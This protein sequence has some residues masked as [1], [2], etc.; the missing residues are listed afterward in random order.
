MS[1]LLSL[2]GGKLL[3]A[4]AAGLA[5]LLALWRAHAAGRQAEQNK[6][7]RKTLDAVKQQR[8]S[9]EKIDRVGDGDLDNWMR[10]HGDFRD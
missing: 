9:D 4:L 7:L 6:S 8:Q 2:I 10:K 3:G 5:L 1:A